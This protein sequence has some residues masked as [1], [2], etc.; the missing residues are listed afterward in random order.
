ME[1]AANGIK[2]T[3]GIQFFLLSQMNS[4]VPGE[5]QKRLCMY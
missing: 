4:S 1:M 3:E 2:T 5:Y